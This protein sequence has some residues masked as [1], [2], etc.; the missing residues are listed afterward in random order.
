[1]Q[2]DVQLETIH[3]KR[4]GETVGRRQ[5]NTKNRREPKDAYGSNQAGVYVYN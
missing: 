4:N 3:I 1:M 5:R 2:R